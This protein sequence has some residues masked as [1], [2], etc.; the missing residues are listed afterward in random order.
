MAQQQS[1]SKKPSLHNTEDARNIDI[2]KVREAEK[3][4]MKNLEKLWWLKKRPDLEWHYIM[5]DVFLVERKDWIWGFWKQ[6]GEPYFSL[7]SIRKVPLFFKDASMF[8]EYLEIQEWGKLNMYKL[9]D[10][11]LETWKPFPD[12]KPVDIYSPEY[13][14]AWNN[15]DFFVSKLSMRSIMKG[16]Y[17]DKNKPRKFIPYP[18]GNIDVEVRVGATRIKELIRLHNQKQI[19]DEAFKKELRR[20]PEL[21]P[22]QCSD[23]RFDRI[24]DPVTIAELK[25]YLNYVNPQ[26]QKQPLIGQNLYDRCVELV[27]KREEHERAQGKINSKTRKELK[28]K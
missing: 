24:E 14:K 27:R 28:R 1:L 3:L 23:E 11:N 4:F 2:Q 21:L 19:S 6:N 22:K 15:L 20:M 7:K 25:W 8:A 13:F 5:P 12:V 16:V 10:I 18:D 26:W 17:K 9:Q